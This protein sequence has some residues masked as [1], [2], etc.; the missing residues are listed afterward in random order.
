MKRLLI[1]YSC[2]IVLA[3]SLVLFGHGRIAYADD[4]QPS[5]HDIINEIEGT[6][7]SGYKPVLSEGNAGDP[8][9]VMRQVMELVR[10][11][12]LG[13]IQNVLNILAILLL[14]IIG[15]QI[16]SI[17]SED[18]A[19][20][21]YKQMVGI[22]SGIVVMNV[23]FDFSRTF[24]ST[25]INTPGNAG[26]L[27]GAARL[28]TVVIEPLINFFLTFLVA[29]AIFSIVLSSFRIITAYGKNEEQQKKSLAILGEA[30]LGL[31]VIGVARIFVTSVYGTY[32][33]IRPNLP[34]GIKFV[35]DA[36]NYGLGFVGMIALVMM[37]YAGFLMLTDLGKG[38]RFKKGTNILRLSVIAIV[39]MLS[40][41]TLSSFL[42]KIFTTI[43]IGGVQ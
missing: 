6:T 41:Y 22:I 4:T 11:D 15:M 9:G 17:H 38:E 19:K 42:V 26:I 7:T 35:M 32:D 20:K 23:A 2:V 1:T 29:L 37:I 14:A 31:V 16:A 25:A 5:Y 13:V 28:N 36:I 12:I 10:T 21:G 33:A 34:L 30:V 24:V 18:A 40:A 39:I 3:L 27:L 43:G 8:V